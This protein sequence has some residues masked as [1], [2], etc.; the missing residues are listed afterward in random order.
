MILFP[1]GSIT[2]VGGLANLLY[3]FRTATGGEQLLNIV[4]IV[5]K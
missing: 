2:R 5:C 1:V 3:S 4:Q